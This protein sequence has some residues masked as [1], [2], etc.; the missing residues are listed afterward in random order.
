MVEMRWVIRKIEPPKRLHHLQSP[1]AYCFKDYGSE[2]VLQYRTLKPT[3]FLHN[4]L[5]WS[6]WVDVPTVRE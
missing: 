4:I 5:E 1:E 2:K 3:P 6:E